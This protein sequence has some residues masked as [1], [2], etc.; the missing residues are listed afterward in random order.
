M[1]NIE[2]RQFQKLLSEY[3]YKKVR[4]SGSSHTVYEREVTVKNVI[5]IPTNNKMLNGPMGQR[6]IKQIAEFDREVCNINCIR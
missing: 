4:S 2:T 5:S 1:Q 3:G 6:L